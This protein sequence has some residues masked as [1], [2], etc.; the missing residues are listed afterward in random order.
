[1]TAQTKRTTPLRV[2]FAASE[3]D[4]LVKVGGLGDVTGSLPRVLAAD[5]G[6]DIRLVIPFH[7]AVRK[8]LKTE[9]EAVADLR[10]PRPKRSL[11][12]RAYR[13][14]I[15]GL[16]VYLIDG[17][18]FR[19]A[20]SVYSLST[21]EDGEKFTFFSLAVLELARALNWQPDV[22]HAHDWHAAL[23]VRMLHAARAADPFFANTRSLLTVHNLP[24]MGAGTDRALRGFGIPAVDEPR[25]PAWG[26]FQPLP[27]GLATADHIS[28]VSPG[29]AAEIQTPEYGCGLEGF[30]QSRSAA[31]SGILNGLD[32]AAWDPATDGALAQ[33]F[34]RQRL[35]ERPANKAALLREVGLTV[36]QDLPLL[37]MIS[38]LDYQKGV[39][40]VIEALRMLR[41]LPWQVVLLGT[42]DPALEQ[43]LSALESEFSY[44]VR[45]ILRFDG[46]LARRMY[47]GGDML[48]MPSRYEPCGTAQMVAM[49]YGNLPVAR[50]TGGLRDTIQD[51]PDPA[52]STGFLCQEAT[53][54]AYAEALRR[55]LLAY[56][57]SA[58]W[59]TRQLL[60][61]TRDF[62][63]DAS[64]QQYKDLYNR[65]A[66]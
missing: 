36:D 6:L 15:D 56:G 63:W 17:A 34:D 5:P 24:F 40:L 19:S 42:G 66:V 18:P 37:V 4:P 13:V 50:A 11:A 57:D 2:L 65:L 12:A 3:A 16:P 58:A 59:R 33:P 21:E 28:T 10:V 61:M 62:S 47:A 48:L 25:M 41:N 27:M 60:G 7:D 52:K 8:N 51:D 9:P 54:P 44:R 30:L 23:S 32:L 45:S 29:Y 53:A 14:E 39:D 31:L 49:R 22:L 43:A 38:R 55:A 26:E 35:D 1:M 46:Q 64:A 20:S